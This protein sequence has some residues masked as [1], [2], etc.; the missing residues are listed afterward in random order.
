MKSATRLLLAI[1][2]AISITTP[3]GPTRV[4]ADVYGVDAHLTCWPGL[5]TA[6]L[7]IGMFGSPRMSQFYVR[8]DGGLW[9]PTDWFYKDF[10]GYAWRWDGANWRTFGQYGAEGQINIG[11]RVGTLVEG[12]ELRD[13]LDGSGAR[14]V[15]MAPCRISYDM[16]AGADIIYSPSR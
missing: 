14:W 3:Q 4:S 9:Y 7:S 12:Y 11:G 15:Q 2:L 10:T 1:A 5:A 16:F 6:S 8:F 13:D